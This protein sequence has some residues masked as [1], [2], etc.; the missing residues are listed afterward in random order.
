MNDKKTLDQIRVAI[1]LRAK[2]KIAGG[3]IDGDKIKG[4]PSMIQNNGLLGAL[5]Y[6]V[7]KKK[8]EIKNQAEYDMSTYI[9]KYITELKANSYSVTGTEDIENPEALIKF[10]TEC[11]PEEF[12]RINAEVMAFLNYFR[13]FAS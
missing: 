3:K 1:S 10:L 12:R 6:S 11:K 2:G 8:T 13:R 9:V 7:E 4:F 5:A